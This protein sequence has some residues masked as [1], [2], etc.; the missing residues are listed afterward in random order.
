[1]RFQAILRP[2]TW[3]QRA[4]QPPAAAAAAPRGGAVASSFPARRR[5]RPPEGRGDRA[6]ATPPRSR[7]G[8]TPLPAPVACGFCLRF[9]GAEEWGA[10]GRVVRG[11]LTRVLISSC[12]M[13]GENFPPRI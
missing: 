11:G 1:V 13:N 8:M 7:C 9:V 12:G 6:R 4:L 10:V 3:R 5:W 2:T